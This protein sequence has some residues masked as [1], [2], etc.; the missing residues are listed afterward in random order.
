MEERISKKQAIQDELRKSY[1]EINQL[2][3]LIKKL[4]NEIERK[5][6]KY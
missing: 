3:L 2:K 4:R 1:N 6:Q 5:I